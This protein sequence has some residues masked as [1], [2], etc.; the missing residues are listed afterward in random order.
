MVRA[1]YGH[2][3]MGNNIKT[4]ISTAWCAIYM[5][6]EE[7]FVVE[8]SLAVAG[9]LIGSVGNTGNSTGSHLHFEVRDPENQPVDPGPSWPQ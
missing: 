3:T 8:G 9:Q 5:H 4:C 2:P 6:L 7:I 1:E